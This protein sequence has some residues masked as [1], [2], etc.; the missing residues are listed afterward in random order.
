[1]RS[2]AVPAT[3]AKRTAI[4]SNPHTLGTTSSHRSKNAGA[5][6]ALL[7][8]LGCVKRITR[9][10]NYEHDTKALLGT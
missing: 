1:M 9:A 10:A 4:L 2:I 5:F 6:R 8:A 3:S 7:T